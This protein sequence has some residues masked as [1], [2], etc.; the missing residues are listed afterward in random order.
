MPIFKRSFLEKSFPNLKSLR[1]ESKNEFNIFTTASNLK[2]KSFYKK[3]F[4]N[5]FKKI[6][7][8]CS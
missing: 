3:S 8:H 1:V 5:L 7:Y 4:D 6:Y 2:Y